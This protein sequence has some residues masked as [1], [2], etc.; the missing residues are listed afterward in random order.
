MQIHRDGCERRS[1]P[2]VLAELLGRLSEMSRVSGECARRI[3]VDAL[4]SCGELESALADAADPAARIVEAETDAL[5]VAALGGPCDVRGLS[6]RLC[7]LV[8]PAHLTLTVADGFAYCGLHPEAYARAAC[9]LRLRAGAGVLVVGIRSIGT[10]LSAV[11]CAALVARGEPSTR[12]TVRPSG[13]PYERRLEL[14]ARQRVAVERARDRDS[15]VLVVDEG[16]GNTGSTFLSTAEALVAAGTPPERI[17]LVCSRPPRVELLGAR[18]AGARFRRFRVVVAPSDIRVPEAE[19]DLS[20][21]AWRAH[22]YGRDDE[23][24]WP[25]SF[26]QTERRKL[27][28]PGAR[29]AKFEGLGRVGRAAHARACALEGAGLGAAPHDEGD[30]FVSYPWEGAPLSLS[31]LDAEVIERLAT[32]CA[33][34]P[35]L[36]PAAAST[37]R[38]SELEQMATTNLELAFGGDMHVAHAP[39]LVVVRP[40]FVDGRMAPHEW[41]RR[42]GRGLMKSD[43]TGH[44]DD[45]FFPGPTDIAWDLAGAIVEWRLGAGAAE[46]L[47]EA[48]QRS[49]GDDPRARLPAWTRAYA[50]FRLAF[51]MVGM[52][53]ARGTRDESRLAREVAGY[54]RIAAAGLA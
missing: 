35:S 50:A 4:V 10:T 42:P 21:G 37:V 19:A 27:L 2:R 44:G 8:V 41:L 46:H 53:A 23:A 9:N 26:T 14:D 47:V 32:Y 16:P 7:T 24:A 25:A 36:C 34:R 43:G 28:M 54:R 6:R 1:G 51:T 5:A 31:D 39:S 13:D 22:A 15:P 12:F 49:S 20:E 33:I 40:A 3:A 48:Y 29:L 52:N 45:L 30:G 38:T 18:D 17:T 11:A